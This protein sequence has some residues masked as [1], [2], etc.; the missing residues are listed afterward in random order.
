MLTSTIFIPE[1]NYYSGMFLKSISLNKNHLPISAEFSENYIIPTS[2]IQLL[3]DDNWSKNF[4]NYKYLYTRMI[5]KYSWPQTF[6][7]RLLIYPNSAQYYILS[8]EDSTSS[9][10]INIFNL[11]NDDFLLLDKL[12]QYRLDTTSVTIIDID[13]TALTTNL[14][15][16][17]Y[18][19]LDLKLNNNYQSYN[20]T[21]LISDETKP[22][23]VLYESFLIENFFTFMTDKGT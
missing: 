12:L 14:S 10:N 18:K 4:N 8:P 15:V 19:Y 17:I 11:Q 3:F 6:R 9:T 21:I 1:L 16:L 20:D 7:D 5:S 22:L 13:S 2:F 23:E